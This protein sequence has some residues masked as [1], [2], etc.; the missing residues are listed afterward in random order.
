MLPRSASMRYQ[1][2]EPRLSLSAGYACLNWIK[3]D[4]HFPAQTIWPPSSSHGTLCVFV[5][6]D[7]PPYGLCS[8]RHTTTL[9]QRAPLLLCS[10]RSSHTAGQ[11]ER[12]L[13]RKGS[14]GGALKCLKPIADRQGFTWAGSAFVY[15]S[16]CSRPHP[17]A[18][19]SPCPEKP[20]R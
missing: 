18:P 17:R 5:T 14:I 15:S 4:L 7:R 6:P 19:L 13:R 2:A 20:R 11:N 3:L 1:P 16:L 12:H 10:S 8:R 9:L